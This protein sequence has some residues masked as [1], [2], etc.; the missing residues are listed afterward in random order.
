MGKR[1]IGYRFNLRVGVPNRDRVRISSWARV[2]THDLPDRSESSRRQAGFESELPG[3]KIGFEI[4]N[5]I[6]SV[7]LNI[8]ILVL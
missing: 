7:L 4:T 6:F 3:K 8:F 1:W 5:Q 2:R